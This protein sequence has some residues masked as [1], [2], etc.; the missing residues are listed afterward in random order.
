MV[1]GCTIHITHTADSSVGIRIGT[2]FESVSSDDFCD[3]ARRYTGVKLDGAF[4]CTG[5]TV[6]HVGGLVEVG[7]QPAQKERRNAHRELGGGKWEGLRTVDHEE[8]GRLE[9]VSFLSHP[10]P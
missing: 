1:R 3:G 2:G 7:H 8:D 10:A 9:D 5:D 4:G 6:N